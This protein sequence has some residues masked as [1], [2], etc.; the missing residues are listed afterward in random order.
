MRSEF[1]DCKDRRT[2]WKRCPWASVIAK[3]CGGFL[4]FES[5]DDYK[6]W[7]AQK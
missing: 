7:K 1:V 6:I 4:A 3:V 5:W 2:A